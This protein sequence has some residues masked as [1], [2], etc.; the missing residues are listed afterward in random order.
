MIDSNSKESNLVM[1]LIV[2]QVALCSGPVQQMNSN[3]NSG[4][5]KSSYA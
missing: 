1:L 4:C 5:N 3:L 2:E